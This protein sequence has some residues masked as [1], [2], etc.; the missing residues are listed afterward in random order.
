VVKLL[1]EDVVT[2]KLAEI[3][4]NLKVVKENLPESFKEFEGLGLVKDGIYKKIEYNIENVLD[5]CAILSADLE[6]GIP[7]SEEDIVDKLMDAKV[8]TKGLGS[9]VKQMKGFRNILVHR[10]GRI[11]DKRAFADI[12]SGIGDFE[13]FRREAE[14]FLKKHK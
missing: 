9:T 5:V 7:A 14:S 3:D 8:L 2:V 1:R 12:K 6:L 11:D 4:E 13:K 10:Y